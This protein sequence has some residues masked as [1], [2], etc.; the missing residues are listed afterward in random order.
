MARLVAIRPDIH[1]ILIGQ[2]EFPEGHL[3]R[4]FAESIKHLIK[5]RNL[6]GQIRLLGRLEASEVLP[7]LQVCDIFVF[8]SRR[9]GLVRVILEAMSVGMPCISSSMD[10][11]AFD[12]I[13]PEVNGI[14][15]NQ[16]EPEAVTDQV[17]RLLKDPELRRRLGEQ[18]RRTV[19]ERFDERDFAAAYRKVFEDVLRARLSINK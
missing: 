17:L 13:E 9:E 7:W 16:V 1:L 5:I 6:Q 2:H 18:A 11:S 8:P 15:L 19:M 12:M 3:A 10:G 4:D 14:I